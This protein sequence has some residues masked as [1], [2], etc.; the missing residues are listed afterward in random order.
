[1]SLL[2][3]EE[4]AQGMAG[5]EGWELAEGSIVRELVFE[6]FLSAIEFVDRIAPVAEKANHHPDIDIRWNRV[7]LLLTTHDQGGL[8]ARDFRLAEEID[9]I[10]PKK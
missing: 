10:A 4:I 7:R 1:M 3:K 8:T 5:L 9:R 2:T 6:G